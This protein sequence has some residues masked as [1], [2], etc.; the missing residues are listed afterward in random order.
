MVVFQ[1][2]TMVQS[3]AFCLGQGLVVALGYFAPQFLV[4]KLVS[5]CIDFAFPEFS[6]YDNVAVFSEG[7]Q[8]VFLPIFA[9]GELV[10][11][12]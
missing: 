5:I 11:L 1:S 6:C 10:T 8:F 9:C 4:F 12:M 7:V 2:S 3:W